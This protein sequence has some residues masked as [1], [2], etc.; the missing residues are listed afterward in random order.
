MEAAE[1]MDGYCLNN[2][3]IAGTITN[4]SNVLRRGKTIESRTPFRHFA[5]EAIRAELKKREETEP[6]WEGSTM[7]RFVW[8]KRVKKW[9]RADESMPEFR[10]WHGELRSPENIRDM[11]PPPDPVVVKANGEG[12]ELKPIASVDATPPTLMGRQEISSLAHE[13]LSGSEKQETLESTD[14][15]VLES[16]SPTT[17]SE[18]PIEPLESNASSPESQTTLT[19][20]DLESTIVNHLSPT[21]SST[22][23]SGNTVS[24]T[25]DLSSKTIGKKARARGD[26]EHWMAWDKF[27]SIVQSISDNAIATLVEPAAVS[28]DKSTLPELSLDPISNYIPDHKDFWYNRQLQAENDEHERRQTIAAHTGDRTPLEMYHMDKFM[29]GAGWTGSV[30][31]EEISERVA[32]W[33]KDGLTGYEH[34][35]VFR[36]GTSMIE[37]RRYT[38][39]GKPMT[40]FWDGSYL[41][42]GHLYDRE[43]M[44]YDH[45]TNSLSFSDGSE[46]IF[47]GRGESKKLLVKIGKQTFDVT[48]TVV[49][50]T[51]KRE[52]LEKASDLFEPARTLS[53]QD[54]TA[55]LATALEVPP[56]L[57]KFEIEHRVKTIEESRDDEVFHDDDPVLMR[58]SQMFEFSDTLSARRFDRFVAKTNKMTDAQ[59]DTGLMDRENFSGDE[60][61]IPEE[62]EENTNYMTKRASTFRPDLI[63]CLNPRENKLAMKEASDNHIP[64]IGICD[65]DSDPRQV[66][67][68][69]PANDDSLRSVEY[70]AG[71]LSRA[72]QEGLIHRQRYHEQMELLLGRA[73]DLTSDSWLDYEILTYD[74][75]SEAPKPTP[76]DGRTKEEILDKYRGFYRVEKAPE[77]MVVKIV[78]QQIVLGQNEI[79]RL[80]MD[81]TDWSMQ[82]HLDHIKSSVQFPGIPVG[83]LEELAQLRLSESRRVWA[84][85]REQVA[86]RP[87][88]YRAPPT[89]I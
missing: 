1:R 18:G 13:M 27:A 65:T 87:Y 45:K 63:V 56:N 73:Q 77:E 22:T 78:A 79:K 36:D 57:V 51:E 31:G 66:T 12:G 71:V 23:D 53:T 81:T 47:E 89:G 55:A 83:V 59:E 69:I 6:L 16:E 17:S 39:E 9:L 15:Q 85:T 88:R 7:I 20:T 86:T 19:E 84:E 54:D 8:D 46:L 28:L 42:N 74:P 4:G 52:I 21:P 29:A 30:R 11:E 61:P 35:K 68:N 25:V 64:T 80:T 49:G 75:D 72:G 40:Q 14:G 70:I 67:Y 37:K 26:L 58:G 76:A 34:V 10:D 3:W 33:K 38:K 44:R 5:D 2:R 62:L 60:S 48:S 50:S 43:G 41:L 32:N 82:Q 24:S